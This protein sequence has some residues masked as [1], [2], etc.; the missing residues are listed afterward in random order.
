MPPPAGYSRAQIALHWIVFALIAAQFL[1]HEPIARAWAAVS[2]GEAAPFSPLVPLHVVTGL[3][4]LALVVWRL[5]LRATHGA[6]APAADKSPAQR[7]AAAAVRVALYALMIAMPVSGAAAW[8]GG[9]EAAAVGH[10][11]MKVALLALV[12]LHVAATL[13]EQ[14]VRKTDPMRRMRTPGA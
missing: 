8:F 5:R 1:L 2:A 13:V 3:A 11:V 4:I 7:R 9:V 6:P 12:A 14:F 10:G